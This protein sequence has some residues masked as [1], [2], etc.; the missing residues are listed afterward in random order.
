M[1]VINDKSKTI[2]NPYLLLTPGPLTTTASV[3]KSMMKDWCTWDNEY[4]NLVQDLRKRVLD[5]ANL[6]SKDYS[7]VLMQ[8]SGTFTI[9]SVIGSSIGSYDKLLVIA[10]GAYGN[11]ISEISK[12][13]K[14]KYE[15][16]DFGETG[17]IDLNTVEKTIK[18]GN[19]THIAMVHCETT[20]GR[21]NSIKEVGGIAKKYSLSYI[22]DAMSSFGGIC[23]DIKDINCDFLIS[24]SN[25]CIQGVPGFGFAIGRIEAIKRCKEQAKSLS[26][27]LYSQ[28]K[29]MEDFNGKW[30]FTSPTHVVRAFY[31]ALLE[32]EAEGGVEA[33]EKRYIEN[34]TILIDGMQNLGYHTLIERDAISPIITTF[35]SPSNDNFDFNKFYKDLKER[36]FVIYPGKLTERDTFRIGNIGDI[37]LKD[38][39]KLLEIINN[40]EY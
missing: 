20:T 27:D 6:N 11:R 18:E 9:E 37:H 19:F 38:I 26:L 2:N 29:T 8:G 28:W 36:G 16:I 40:I 21:L 3:K 5:I 10:N 39:K 14:L 33:R 17:A 4:T 24:S 32:L 12:V 22:V 31:Q 34:N 23:I 15:I 25:K 1:N 7:V 30:R 13:L 35:L